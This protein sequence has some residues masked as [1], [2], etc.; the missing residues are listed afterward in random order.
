MPFIKFDHNDIETIIVL[1]EEVEVSER[2]PAEHSLLG[3]ALQIRGAQ[4]LKHSSNVQLGN[5][6]RVTVT[7]DYDASAVIRIPK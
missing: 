3:K 1:I 2:T 4:A 6:R 5:V 7:N